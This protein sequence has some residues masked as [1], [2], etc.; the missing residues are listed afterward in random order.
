[1]ATTTT[2]LRSIK[3]TKLINVE[4][5][6]PMSAMQ[7]GIL[8][9]CLYEPGLGMYCLQVSCQIEAVLD[10]RAFRRAWK[11]VVRR[12]AILRTKFL[13]EGLDKPRQVVR[14]SVEL[15]WREE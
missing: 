4:D 7:Q 6:Y 2:D 1:M 5:I 9:H 14:K 8:F 10:V 3:P 13:W 12:H 15:P 11:E